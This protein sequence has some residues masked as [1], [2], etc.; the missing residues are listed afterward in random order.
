MK[1]K[2]QAGFNCAA[3][4]LIS[5]SCEAQSL[6]DVYQKARAKDSQFAVARHALEAAIEKLPQARAGILPAVSLTANASR[7]T[8][9]GWFSGGA[10]SGAS[11]VSRE[12]HAW[13]WTTQITQPLIRVGNWAAYAQADAQVTQAKEQFLQAEQDLIVRTAQAYFD[14]QLAMHGTYVA[15]A[16]LN[17]IN[18]QLT[19]A[20]RTY[21]VGMGTIT[22]VH[23]AKAKQALSVAQHVN[24]L[25]DFAS[26]EAELEILAG[27]Y[28][29]LP[30]MQIRKS[31]PTLDASQIDDWVTAALQQNPQIRIQQS[32][33]LVAS[34]EVTKSMAA[35]APTLDIVAN[36]AANY[37]SGTLSSPADVSTRTFSY[38]TGLQLTIPLFAGGSMQSKVRESLALQEKAKEEFTSA[39]RNVKIQVRQGFAG[40]MNGQSQVLAL[41]AAVEAS[42]NSVESNK[43]G[44]KVGTRI[45]PDVLN[46]EQQLYTAMRDLNKARV[47][48]VM[49]SLKLKATTGALTGDDLMAIENLMQPVQLTLSKLKAK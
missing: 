24:A 39:Q 17:A 42:Q 11:T 15:Q 14:V 4:L 34:K 37:S 35:H 49:Q 48:V 3:L 41:E 6:L 31:L 26:R 27:E 46:A 2:L 18:E 12:V 5:W 10:Y 13:N 23:E 7:Q 47:D 29:R 16:Q 28:L 38:Q 22:D 36:R 45:N 44:F 20:Q 40:V 33:L 43:I 21:E 25:N 19:L 1:D 30:P 9:D 8:G 32:A